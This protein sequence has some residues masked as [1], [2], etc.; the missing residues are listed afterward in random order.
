MN[1]FRLDLQLL[2][3]LL[4]GINTFCAN[5]EES[6]PSPPSNS[7]ETGI[8]AIDSDYL[9]LYTQKTTLPIPGGLGVFV[10]QDIPSGEILCEYR[11]HVIPRDTIFASDKKYDISIGDELFVVVGT[12]ICAYVNDC[13]HINNNSFTEE[14]L[15]RFKESDKADIIPL[16]PGYSYNIIPIVTRVGKVFLAS[17]TFIPAHSELF[18]PYGK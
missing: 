12:N 7:Q 11:G 17:S 8:E 15:I 6:E 3:L 2:L 18:F 1:G 9:V 10:K 16:Y 4:L 13:A 14:D 5:S